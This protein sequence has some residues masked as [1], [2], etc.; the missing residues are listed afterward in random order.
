MKQRINLFFKEIGLYDEDMFMYIEQHKI[1]IK[2]EEDIG[3]FV[4]CFPI[5]DN[6]ILKSFRL[7]V[8]S[9]EG[10]LY[11]L[12]NVHEYGHAI[13]LYKCL[14]QQYEDQL[15]TEVLPLALERLYARSI[16]MEKEYLKLQEENLIKIRGNELYERY[17]LAFDLQEQ[18]LSENL[19]NISFNK[20]CISI[21]RK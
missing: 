7:F 9:K 2:K 14:N 18:L 19:N 12:M 13:S 20:G 11:E 3:I 10:F 16:G 1:E 5:I 15:H 6:N 21:R 8:P 17:K 4:G